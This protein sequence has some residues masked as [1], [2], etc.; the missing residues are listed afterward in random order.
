MDFVLSSSSS[1][2]TAGSETPHIMQELEDVM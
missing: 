2:V 1:M